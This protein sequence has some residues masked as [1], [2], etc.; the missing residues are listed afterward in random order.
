[1]RKMVATKTMNLEIHLCV[2]DVENE[3]QY[4]SRGSGAGSVT[5][6]IGLSDCGMPMQLAAPNLVLKQTKAAGIS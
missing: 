2:K 1:M 3:G 5:H 4:T 6:S